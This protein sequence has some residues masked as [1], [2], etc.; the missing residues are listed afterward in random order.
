MKKLLYIVISWCLTCSIF[1]RG[2]VG[3]I[4]TKGKGGSPIH[5]VAPGSKS[6]KGK[7]IAGK[8]AGTPTRAAF[9]AG[10]GVRKVTNFLH[11][12]KKNK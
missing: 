11:I 7:S 12:T 9:K 3:H 2:G 1:A 10:Q 8:I 5:H 4:S 6:L